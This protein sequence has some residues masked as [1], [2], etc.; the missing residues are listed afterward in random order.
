M[1]YIYFMPDFSIVCSYAVCS[2]VQTITVRCR[3]RLDALLTEA[4]GRS[5]ALLTEAEG[6]L[7]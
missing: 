6:R 3:G 5:D 1:I 7:Q 2:I 4:E